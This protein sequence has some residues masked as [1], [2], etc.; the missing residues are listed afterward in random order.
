VE[1]RCLAERVK[2]GW[3]SI[4]VTLPHGDQLDSKE[5]F[6]GIFDQLSRLSKTRQFRSQRL[7]FVVDGAQ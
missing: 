3:F 7:I 6:I 1:R 4:Q 2:W 5:F